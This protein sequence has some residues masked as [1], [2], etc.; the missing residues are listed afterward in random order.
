MENF[1]LGIQIGGLLVGLILIC[2]GAIGGIHLLGKRDIFFTF[3]EEGTAKAIMKFNGFHKIVMQYE[4][5][6]LDKEGN[7]IVLEPEKRK[8]QKKIPKLF[9]LGGLKWVGIPGIHSVYSYR[10]TWAT[11]KPQKEEREQIE[12]RSELIKHIFV[13]DYVYLGEVRGAET[14]SLVPLDISF[15]ITARVINPYNALFRVHDWVNV[16]TSR[17]EAYFRQFVSQTEYDDLIAKK[18]EMSGEIMKALTE[19]GILG[20][21]GKF[22]V[23]YGIKVKNIEMRDIE[24]V[25]ENKKI[26]QEAATKKW[27]AEKQKDQIVT[28]ADAEVQKINKVYTEIRKFGEEGLTIR[29]LES[30]DKAGEKQGNWIIP[31]G[32]VKQLLEGLVGK[33]G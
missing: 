32:S 20:D 23:D 28:I 14:K 24:P 16:I 31:F 10:F 4:N 11:V 18:Q 5:C 12:R 25:G 19:T 2:F 33:K 13:K 6:R 26:L 21:E 3:V 27:V 7:V 8:K 17:I 1:I 9:G 22:Y 29:M 15:L 30:I